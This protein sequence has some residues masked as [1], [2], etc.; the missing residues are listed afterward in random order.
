M[1]AFCTAQSARHS[2]LGGKDTQEPSLIFQ[3]YCALTFFTRTVTAL[4]TVATGATLS[5]Q[6]RTNRRMSLPFSSKLG[7][8]SKGVHVRLGTGG[9]LFVEGGEMGRAM[10]ARSVMNQYAPGMKKANFSSMHRCVSVSKHFIITYNLCLRTEQWRQGV[11]STSMHLESE[12][13]Q[14]HAQE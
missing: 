4:M 8:S 6:K 1:A 13:C 14:F 9:Q 2:R 5:L 11:A 3:R 10:G 7:S 12:R